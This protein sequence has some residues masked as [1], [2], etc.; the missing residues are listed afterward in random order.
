MTK[1]LVAFVALLLLLFHFLRRFERAR[2]E[3]RGTDKAAVTTLLT[4]MFAG[5]GVLGVLLLTQPHFF[6]SI[7]SSRN[8]CIRTSVPLF[9]KEGPRSTQTKWREA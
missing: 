4:A 1:F 2:P 5:G 3:D 6:A 7:I 9:K 8:S